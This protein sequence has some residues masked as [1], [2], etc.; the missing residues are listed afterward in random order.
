[1]SLVCAQ[2]R[3]SQIN[4][5]Y[6]T[7]PNP[8]LSAKDLLRVR[9]DLLNK[10][11]IYYIQANSV[12]FP[13]YCD[14]TSRGGG[15]TMIVAQFEN[16]SV[17]SWGEGRQADYDPSLITGRGFCLSADEIPH[18]TETAFG[19]DFDA[20]FSCAV[21]CKYVTGN[22]PKTLVTD[23]QTGVQYHIHRSTTG[24]Y[25]YHNPEDA[26]YENMSVWN[27]TLTCDRVGGQYHSWAFS[28]AYSAD[29]G[30]KGYSMLG[31]TTGVNSFAWT[32]WVR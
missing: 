29:A 14:M 1:M 8:A 21:L 24:F 3:D 2:P 22:I 20:D 5:L 17:L 18:H 25:Y 16:D 26:R 19:K 11:G 12:T 30:Y 28:P 31:I 15:W 32:V 9:P 27:N 7:L 23:L 4:A 10:N 6:G 13:V